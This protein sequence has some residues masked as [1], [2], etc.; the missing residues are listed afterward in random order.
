MSDQKNTL[1]QADNTR[2]EPLLNETVK[3]ILPSA[4]QASPEQCLPIAHQASIRHFWACTNC[5][6][7][8][9]WDLKY[10]KMTDYANEAN[11]HTRT[12]VHGIETHGGFALQ[13]CS[14]MLSE[15]IGLFSIPRCFIIGS[16]GPMF[17]IREQQYGWQP[18]K[19]IWEVGRLGWWKLRE[20]NNQKGQRSLKICKCNGHVFQK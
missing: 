6:I 10:T 19:R 12:K 14:T 5:T 11:L 13:A 17:S 9:G 4:C 20:S 1:C 8:L 16:F 2:S 15:I 3:Q 7:L 18:S